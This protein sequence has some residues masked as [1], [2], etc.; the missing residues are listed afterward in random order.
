[1]LR[2]SSDRSLI[3]VLCLAC[4]TGGLQAQPAQSA[5]D[6]QL[7]IATGKGDVKA[8]ADL[9]A[10]GANVNATNK[11]GT[12]PLFMAADRANV[13]LVRLLLQHGA[14]P[15]AAE[16]QWGKSP[17]GIVA[18]PSSD[19]KAPEARAEIIK[20]LLEKGAG[21]DGQPLVDLIRAGHTD[22]AATIVSRGGIKSPSYLNNALAAAKQK[23]H[24]ALVDL[25]V[26]SGA[27]DPGPED[28]ARAPERLE[29]LRGRYRSKG[30]TELTLSLSPEE[31]QLV[32]QRAGTQPILVFPVGL[33]VLKS[34]DLNV[35]VT[36]DAHP[37]P[38]P[39]V[40]LREG[41]SADVFT[42]MG[43]KE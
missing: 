36:F 28:S 8:V 19:N 1:M 9:L 42:R 25:L 35:I 18:V 39:A 37:V 38:P 6:R 5:D 33:T 24:V 10:K 14:D 11:Y 31:D 13:E 21:T 16:L 32:L 23:S 30:G 29:L 41:G 15:N 43:D 7:L 40:T 27:K 2:S 3:L 22:V 34:M 20:L 26:R 4:G 12:S 17:L